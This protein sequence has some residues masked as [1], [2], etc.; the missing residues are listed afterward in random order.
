VQGREYPVPLV[1]NMVRFYRDLI[2]AY[3]ARPKD[4]PFNLGPWQSRLLA[5]QA[6]RDSARSTG[7]RALLDE[8]RQPVPA[9][10][11]P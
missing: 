8:A 9:A 11:V 5:I 1:H 4:E 2:D 7:T 6:E 10:Q 3:I